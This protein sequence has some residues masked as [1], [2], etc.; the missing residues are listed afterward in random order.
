MVEDFKYKESDPYEIV[1]YDQWM[2][3]VVVDGLQ[4]LVLLSLPSSPPSDTIT[5]TAKAWCEAFM[6]VS[7]EWDEDLDTRRF[8]KGF[9]K[10]KPAVKHW[11]TPEQFLTIMPG[12]P[13][14]K[15]LPPRR[16][17]DLTPEERELNL[18]WLA[19]IKEQIKEL[20]KKKSMPEAKSM[21]ELMADHQKKL[22]KKR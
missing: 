4:Q 2:L 18:G 19:K 13:K 3:N 6:E 22:K 10:L 20:E 14:P 7:K 17:A 9:A 21:P 15:A 16:P 5:F 8:I 1:P 12:R 11:P